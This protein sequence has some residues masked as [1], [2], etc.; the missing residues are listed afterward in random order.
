MMNRTLRFGLFASMLGLAACD[1]NPLTRNARLLLTVNMPTQTEGEFASTLGGR[2]KPEFGM[3]VVA[4]GTPAWAAAPNSY[5]F[6]R[7]DGS[8]EIP[9]VEG[10]A[11]PQELSLL[12]E[13]GFD[14]PITVLVRVCRDE[15]D[16]SGSPPTGPARDHIWVIE[17]GLYKAET[18]NITLPINDATDPRTP[19]PYGCTLDEWGARSEILE[20]SVD[21]NTIELSRCFVQGCSA[22]SGNIIWGCTGLGGNPSAMFDNDCDLEP[23]EPVHNCDVAD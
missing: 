20:T 4:A 23:E 9:L 5:Q 11:N 10:T 6:A 12:A 14:R 2:V 7:T 3:I 18:T 13:D 8:F 16:C 1:E 21:A 19:A 15:T 22:Q 17:R